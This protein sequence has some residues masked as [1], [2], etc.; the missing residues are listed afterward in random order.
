MHKYAINPSSELIDASYKS[1]PPSVQPL[2]LSD[3][4]KQHWNL[5]NGD[6]P[7]PSAVLLQSALQNNSRWM[8]AFLKYTGVSFAPHGKTTMAPQL[9]A[10][11]LRDGAWGITAATMQQV[12]VCW[13]SGIRRIILANQL[14]GDTESAAIIAM[15]KADPELDFYCLVDSAEGSERLSQMLVRANLTRPVKVLIEMGFLGGRAG[16]RTID[17]ALRLAKKLSSMSGIQLSGVECFEGYIRGEHPDQDAIEVRA[18]LNNVVQLAELCDQEHLFD[19]TNEIILTAGGSSY[20][21]LVTDSFKRAML[22]KPIRVVIR[23]GCY[24]T[25]DSS[26]QESM[27]KHMQRRFPENFP[28]TYPFRSALQIWSVVQ[29]RP[30]PDLAILS[31]GKRDASYDMDLPVVQS[32]LSRGTKHPQKT[33]RE[34]CIIKLNDQHAFLRIPKDASLSIGDYI[35]CGISHPCTT[36]DKWRLIYIVDDDYNVVD[37]VKTWF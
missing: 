22:S 5:L 11:Q 37:A 14:V 16:C 25:H 30:E 28:I 21:D 3:I 2:R 18:L 20:F 19:I 8:Q 15:L 29:S 1:F 9:F 26:F 4:G 27:F 12:Y 7:L 24:L 23:S 10:Q 35:A 33:P 36:F 32:W 34:W 17:Q 13:Q 6:I 31:F